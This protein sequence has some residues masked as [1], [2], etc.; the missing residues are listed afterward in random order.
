MPRWTAFA[1]LGFLLLGVGSASSS[2]MKGHY[3]HGDIEVNDNLRG[4][5]QPGSTLTFRETFRGNQ[6]ACVLVEGDHKPE[7]N[8]KIVVTD[9]EGKV[10]AEDRGPG[11]FVSAF[12]YPPR[13]Q[14]YVISISG[15]GKIVNYLDIVV[16]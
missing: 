10:V 15:D 9:P 8:L 12:W 4:Q 6:R 13:T 1:I 11:D 16:K 7:M 3:R 14:Q 2:P 5:L